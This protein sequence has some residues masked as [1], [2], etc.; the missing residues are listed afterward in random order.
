MKNETLQRLPNAFVDSIRRACNK[1]KTLE[2]GVWYVMGEPT[3]ALT[4]EEARAVQK[5]ERKPTEWINLEE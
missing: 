2:P 1:S 5:G 3:D 4:F